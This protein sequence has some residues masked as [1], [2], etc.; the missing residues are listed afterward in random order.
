MPSLKPLWLSIGP[1]SEQLARSSSLHLGLDFDGTLTDLLPDPQSCQLAG[2]A[3]EV[4]HRLSGR[5]QLH[6][7]FFSSRT[8]EDLRGRVGLE[9]AFYAGSSGL[10]TRSELGRYETHAG[11][12]TSLPP[13]LVRDLTDWCQRFPGARLELR[14]GSC[15][16]HFNAVAVALQPAFGAGIRRR[17]RPH[18][19]QVNLIHGRAKFEV[20]PATA[21]DKAAA[22]EYW[23]SSAPETTLLLYFG[24]DTRDEPVHASVRRRAGIAIAVDRV[25][26]RAEYVLP[27]PADV[28]WFLEWLDREWAQ[29]GARPTAPDPRIRAGAPIEKART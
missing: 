9:R 23:L 17:L 7:A 2:R 27:T 24:D 1:L 6:L 12:M 25:V 19:P 28:I 22:L 29:R 5:D 8:L 3:R 10:E 11:P 4:L 20:V 16:L 14:P 18:Q 26:S 15:A 13:A 21:W